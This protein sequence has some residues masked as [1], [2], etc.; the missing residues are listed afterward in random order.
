MPLALPASFEVYT[1]YEQAEPLSLAERDEFVMYAWHSSEYDVEVSIVRSPVGRYGPADEYAS[2]LEAVAKQDGDA[3]TVRRVSVGTGNYPASRLDSEYT[4][5]EGDPPS[6]DVTYV[7]GDG[8]D[9][10]EVVYTSTGPDYDRFKD[11]FERS[12]STFSTSTGD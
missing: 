6:H 11:V 10:W 4:L 1:D 2:W 3:V 5:L 9:V 7:I 12:I 8:Y